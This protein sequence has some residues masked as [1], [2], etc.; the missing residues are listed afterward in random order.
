MEGFHRDGGGTMVEKAFTAKDA[1]KLKEGLEKSFAK[2]FPKLMAE[3]NF[4]QK[5]L[6]SANEAL[7]H[8]RGEKKLKSR[9]V[10]LKKSGKDG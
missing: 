7:A 6:K 8:V 3:T 10:T 9:K 2:K 5:L 1:R 4:G